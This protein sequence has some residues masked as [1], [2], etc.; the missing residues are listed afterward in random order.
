[1]PSADVVVMGAGPA[2]MAAAITAAGAG[3]RVAVVETS[4]RPRDRPGETLHPGVEPLFDQ[5]G[6]GEAVRAAAFVRH[7]GVRVVWEGPPRFVPY[8]AQR[9]RPW[10]G[11]QAWRS[12]LDEILRRRAATLGV[13]LYAGTRATGLRRAGR[14]L[15]GVQ[16]AAGN[17]DATWVVDAAG[18]GQWVARRAGL[19]IVCVSPRL[20]AYY[21]YVHRPGGE[22]PSLEADAGGWTWRAEVLPGLYQ[23]TRLS[24]DNRPPPDA[25]VDEATGR[26]RAADVTW[27]WVPACAG[28]GYFLAGDAAAVLDPSSSHGVLRA[29][30]SGILAGHSIARVRQGRW[31]EAE[32]CAHYRR[33]MRDWI[34]HDVREL[35]ALYARLPAPPQWLPCVPDPPFPS[36]PRT[37]D[38]AELG[39]LVELTGVEPVTS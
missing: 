38:P 29:V 28:A 35:K 10:L 6:V 15:A 22:L 7:A 36:V 34:E 32:A 8:G 2:G 25:L 31:C 9:G 4:V 13:A 23:W 19:P 20:L 11:F 27:R 16:T 1:M 17:L 24:F 39:E 14:R 12:T 26:R 5:L 3:L 18:S 33:W 30:M 37:C 21:G